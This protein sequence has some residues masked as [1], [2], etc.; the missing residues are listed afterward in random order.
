MS[1]VIKFPVVQKK[2][3]VLMWL[4]ESVGCAEDIQEKI[5]HFNA[6]VAKM[7]PNKIVKLEL[8]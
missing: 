4:Y 2:R 6:T 3:S 8:K 7:N 5:E 1:N